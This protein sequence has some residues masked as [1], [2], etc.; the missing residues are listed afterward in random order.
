MSVKITLPQEFE[1]RREENTEINW[2]IV[3][4][5]D[6]DDSFD[7]DCRTGACS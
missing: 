7:M 4:V 1:E 5:Y 3:A 2:K 6:L